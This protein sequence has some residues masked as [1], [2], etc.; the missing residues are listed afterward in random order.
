MLL[1][2]SVSLRRDVGFGFTFLMELSRYYFDIE[3]GFISYSC[4]LMFGS[5]L[6]EAYF[7]I[8]F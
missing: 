2:E 1:I 8:F 5:R 6:I 3:R 4:F 7:L